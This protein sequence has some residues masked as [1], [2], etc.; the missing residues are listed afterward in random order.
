MDNTK[1]VAGRAS[2]NLHETVETN[3]NEIEIKVIENKRKLNEL[4]K[5]EVNLNRLKITEIGE[6]RLNLKGDLKRHYPI[7]FITFLKTK[8]N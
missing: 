4:L 5:Q 6:N 3:K 2:Q 7:R 1:I 8:E